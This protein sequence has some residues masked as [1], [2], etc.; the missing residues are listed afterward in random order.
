MTL[1]FYS[2]ELLAFNEQLEGETQTI[3]LVVKKES[4]LNTIWDFILAS[5]NEPEGL[6][7]CYFAEFKSER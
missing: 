5:F 4:C 2:S 6:A 7:K 3:S 1:S